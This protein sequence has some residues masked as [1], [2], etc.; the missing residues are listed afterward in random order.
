M[1]VFR[2]L[3]VPGHIDE[4]RRMIAP[5]RGTRV[6]VTDAVRMR[7]FS[8]SGVIALS[9]TGSSQH[10]FLR[11]GGDSIPLRYD[12]LNRIQVEVRLSSP[13]PCDS[14]A[15]AGSSSQGIKAVMAS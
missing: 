11:D 3:E 9:D 7:G 2:D 14:P 15:Y 5:L 6:I 1:K 4:R 13:N 12:T 10:Y 8:L